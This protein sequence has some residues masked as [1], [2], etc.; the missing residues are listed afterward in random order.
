M[1]DIPEFQSLF[2]WNALVEPGVAND[3]SDCIAFQ[4][5]FLWNALVETAG[6]NVR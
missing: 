6:C 2:L 4:S 3:P 1:P 5:L